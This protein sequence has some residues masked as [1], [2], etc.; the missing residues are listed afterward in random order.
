MHRLRKGLRET[1]VGMGAVDD[2]KEM[3]RKS[4]RCGRAG[5]ALTLAQ[6]KDLFHSEN[7]KHM[8]GSHSTVHYDVVRTWL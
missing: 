1:R 2:S 3:G 4:R 5:Q 7:P 6:E 8:V